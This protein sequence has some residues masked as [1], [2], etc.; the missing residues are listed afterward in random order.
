MDGGLTLR[1]VAGEANYSQFYV[2][3][4]DPDFI[5]PSCRPKFSPHMKIK[6]VS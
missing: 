6:K 4:I 1:A 2:I 5:Q 3:G